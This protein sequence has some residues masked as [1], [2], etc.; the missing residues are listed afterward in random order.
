MG[1]THDS[2]VVSAFA[3]TEFSALGTTLTATIEPTIRSTF[4]T[5]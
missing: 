5:T 2:A 1:N 4:I 3:A